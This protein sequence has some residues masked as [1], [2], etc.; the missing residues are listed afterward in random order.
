MDN[1][2]RLNA[3]VIKGEKSEG[4]AITFRRG[5][6]HGRPL[7]VLNYSFKLF[8][9]DIDSQHECTV[10]PK[11]LYALAERGDIIGVTSDEK[12]LCVSVISQ[13][14]AECLNLVRCIGVTPSCDV[15]FGLEN[16]VSEGDRKRLAEFKR[17]RNKPCLSTWDNVYWSKN[18]GIFYSASHYVPRF[19]LIT[20]DEGIYDYYVFSDSGK[21]RKEVLATSNIIDAVLS[22]KNYCC[23]Y[24]DGRNF[25]VGMWSG[26]SVS[27]YAVYACRPKFILE[28]CS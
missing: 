25:V 18:T 3:I 11:Q 17:L 10:S 26:G 24:N 27:Y 19:N 1:M 8:I 21:S 4:T 14:A 6:S 12:C 22:D 28:V 5:I 23:F 20:G 16:A 15:E 9:V 7:A 2:Y 13:R